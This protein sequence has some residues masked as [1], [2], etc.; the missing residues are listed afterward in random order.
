[1]NVVIKETGKRE[2]L[3]IL[4]ET[5]IEWTHVLIGNADG[6]REG[7]FVWSEE[8]D[9]YLADQDTYDW[10]SAYITDSNTTD[11]E[12]IALADELGISKS[13]IHNRIATNTSADYDRHRKEALIAMEVI[14]EEY[15]AK[16]LDVW[17]ANTAEL[18]RQWPNMEGMPDLQGVD[19]FSHLPISGEPTP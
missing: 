2:A 19:V 4:S 15:G 18:A 7:R 8:E 11:Q 5:G 16:D 13:I 1:M 12:V 14:R 10:W 6:F 17:R 9:A 3:T